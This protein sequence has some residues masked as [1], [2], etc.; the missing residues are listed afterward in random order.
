MIFFWKIKNSSLCEGDSDLMFF[1]YFGALQRRI[2]LFYTLF[3]VYFI[4]IFVI[5]VIRS[6]FWV[7][8]H[9]FTTSASKVI[10]ILI[11]SG[12]RSKKSLIFM[13]KCWYQQNFARFCQI[14]NINTIFLEF[15][16]FSTFLPTKMAF[17]A[18]FADF[19]QGA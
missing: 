18:I 17:R 19:K 1:L 13:K 3:K 10:D 5:Y 14:L 15:S 8:I 2:S 12:N 16:W 6:F 4:Y 9:I 11:N 7:V